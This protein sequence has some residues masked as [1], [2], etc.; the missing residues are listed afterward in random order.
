MQFLGKYLYLWLVESADVGNPLIEMTEI[1]SSLWP[2]F[3]DG[4]LTRSSLHK[5]NMGETERDHS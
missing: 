2:N 1:P 3:P 5:V 4:S